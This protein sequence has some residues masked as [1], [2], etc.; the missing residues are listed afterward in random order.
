MWNIFLKMF[1]LNWCWEQFFLSSNHDKIWASNTCSCFLLG[2]PPIQQHDGLSRSIVLNLNDLYFTALY[3]EVKD[4]KH[5]T[6]VSSDHKSHFL[7]WEWTTCSAER[8]W[9]FL[10]AV[11]ILLPLSSEV[12]RTHKTFPKYM[13]CADSASVLQLFLACCWP[14]G[15]FSCRASS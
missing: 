1:S 4:Q 15:G 13:L 7:S 11:F 9:A 10:W 14:L 3:L 6:L 2:L 12:F 8:T 5:S